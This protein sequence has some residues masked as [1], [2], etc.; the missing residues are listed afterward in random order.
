MA[1]LNSW[2]KISRV[3]PGQPFGNGADGAY[4]ST[5]IPTLTVKTCAGA[6]TETTLTADTDAS[7]FAAGDVLLLH[8]SRGTGV[9]QW[10][11]NRVSAV[12][13]DQYTLQT[14]LYYTYTDSG[15]SQAQAIKIPQ[16]SSMNVASG[17]WGVTAWGGDVG[18][19]FPIAC[20]GDSTLACTISLAGANGATGTGS[21]AGGAGIGHTGGQGISN[22]GAPAYCGEGSGGATSTTTSANGN[23]GGGG[24]ATN[25]GG[26]YGFGGGGGHAVAG[27]TGA[28]AVSGVGGTGGAQVGGADLT[29][30]FFGGSGGGGSRSGTTTI[31]G[32]GAGGGIFLL[33]AK[34]PDVSSATISSNGGNSGNG[35]NSGGN[36]AGG[37]CLVVCNTATLGT[38]K[39]TA[40]KGSGGTA[41][42]DGRIAIHHSGTVSGTTNPTFEDVSDSTLIE[43]VGSY[44]FMSA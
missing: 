5:D 24:D 44:I 2:Q 6:A 12:G 18:G 38:N 30:M 27:T 15:A 23:S 29:G 13:S 16:Y 22:N 21:A 7:P 19:I 37:S 9:G 8:Q 26:S 33:M 4:T 31:D 36:G 41:A 3:L 10:E 11:I 14:A 42:S 25:D 17:T 34:N 28:T 39:I 40:V 20:N 1:N 43:D 35:Y 32:G